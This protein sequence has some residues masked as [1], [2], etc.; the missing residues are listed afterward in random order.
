[1]NVK[2]TTNFV[3]GIIFLALQIFSI[4]YARFIPE[5][6]FC[7]APYDIHTKYSI[8]VQID[9]NDLT[10]NEIKMRYRYHSHGWEP[11]SIFNVISLVKQYENTYGSDEGADVSI[12]YSINGKP[13]Q[14]WKHKH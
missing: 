12:Y 5:R 6:F 9:G 14:I 3:A 10:N 4:V 13:E 8:H 7:W 2:L 1:M 11:R